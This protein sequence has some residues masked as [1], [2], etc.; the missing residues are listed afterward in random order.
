MIVKKLLL[1]I[2]VVLTVHSIKGMEPELKETGPG[3]SKKVRI[4][5]SYGVDENYRIN[6]AYIDII[7]KDS[8]IIKIIHTL[9]GYVYWRNISPEVKRIYEEHPRMERFYG[10]FRN[11]LNQLPISMTVPPNVGKK[12][13]KFWI[14]GSHSIGKIQ[15]LF[16]TPLLLEEVN[17]NKLV[18]GLASIKIILNK[19]QKKSLKRMQ[20]AKSKS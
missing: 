18:Y 19:E 4:I 3:D 5:N 6:D 17:E 20:P 14:S 11:S 10:D 7:F 13:F 8:K 12:T 1:T 16:S 15:E 2:F 9:E